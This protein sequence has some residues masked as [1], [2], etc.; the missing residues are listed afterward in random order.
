MDLTELLENP[1]YQTN[2]ARVINRAA[3]NVHLESAIRQFTLDEIIH[4]LHEA[5]VPAARIRDMALVFQLPAA[6]AMILDE[7][8]ENGEKTRR[9]KTIAFKIS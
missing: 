5:K 3:L 1:D 9:M 7:T 6:Q 4:K 8:L 2:K